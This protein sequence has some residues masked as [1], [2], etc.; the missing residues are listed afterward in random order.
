MKRMVLLSIGILIA[1]IYFVPSLNAAVLRASRLGSPIRLTVLPDGELGADGWYHGPVRVRATSTPE[2]VITYRLNG[3]E[4]VAGNEVLLEEPGE[5][6]IEW[7]ACDGGRCH[8]GFEQAIKIVTVELRPLSY[9]PDRREWSFPAQVIAVRDVQLLRSPGQVA[10][11]KARDLEVWVV[12]RV[13]RLSLA[14]SDVEVGDLVRVSIAGP[15]VSLNE[16]DWSQ[17][18]NV[19]ARGVSSYEYCAMGDVLDDGLFGL[20]AGYKLSPSNELIRAGRASRTWQNGVLY[21]HT[22]LMMSEG[23]QH[24]DR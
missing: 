22:S 13:G 15:H 8:D 16:I 9:D 17:C 21:W 7:N 12:L 19:E 5:Y 24:H 18:A 23:D 20:D 14:D 4:V 10:R 3:G 6:A 1:L 2:A 11:V